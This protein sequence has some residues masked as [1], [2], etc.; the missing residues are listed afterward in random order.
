MK[1]FPLHSCVPFTLM[2]FMRSWFLE[3]YVNKILE[4]ALQGCYSKQPEPYLGDRQTSTIELFE[5]IVNGF[6]PLTIF[7][8]I[9]NV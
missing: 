5:E 8:K 3:I 6:K 2:T 7:A 9:I 4:E 1:G